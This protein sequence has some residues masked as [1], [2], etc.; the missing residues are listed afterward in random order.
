[1][2]CFK[3]LLILTFLIGFSSMGYCVQNSQGNLSS[4]IQLQSVSSVTSKA[5]NEASFDS[6]PYADVMND[7]MIN[8]M[9][10]GMNNMLQNGNVSPYAVNEMQKQQLE[11]AKQQAQYMKQMDAED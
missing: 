9:M 1:M 2:K 8:S 3:M 11:Y 7:P 10:G 4:K 5:N 6:L